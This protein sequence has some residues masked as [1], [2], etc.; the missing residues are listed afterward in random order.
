[1]KEYFNIG[2]N[3]TSAVA[4]GGITYLKNLIKQ[5]SILDKKN[6]YFIYSTTNVIKEL[7]PYVNLETSQ[8]FNWVDCKVP[9]LSPIVRV[10]WEQFILPSVLKKS[11]IDILFSP[12]N[13]GMVFSSTPFI[14]MVRNMAVFDDDFIKSET[15]YQKLRLKLL[16]I[17]TLLSIKR[18]KKVIFI[19]K[20]AQNTVCE[21]YNI[22]QSKTVLI[23]HGKKEN[24]GFEFNASQINDIK[25][26]YNLDKYILYVSNIYKYKNIY[27]LF[28]AFIK[29]KDKINSDI[30][31]V[32]AGINFDDTYYKKLE[33]LITTHQIAHR[34]RLIG[35]VSND[36]LPLLYA[37]T[38][39]FVYPS[40]IENCPNIL[41]E[42]MASGAA[43]VSS[44][45]NPMPEICED[46]A[47]YF[48]PNNPDDI[49][50]KMLKMLESDVLRNY[51]SKKALERATYFC[52]EKTAKNTLAVLEDVSV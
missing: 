32:V 25:N 29:I 33:A 51:F 27:E 31:L 37:N 50:D 52:W 14:L 15:N 7:S 6:Q 11:K 43:I 39:L 30:Q 38:Q 28:L 46:A 26:I 22:N 8:N 1:M 42:A 44:N 2:I 21:R 18:A 19:S 49:A 5:L 34:I 9:A 35:H 23:Y 20:T 41:I 47:L 10:F 13:I 48:D 4:G 12:A 24:H 17:L 40:T 16:Q 45:I 3:I 36:H